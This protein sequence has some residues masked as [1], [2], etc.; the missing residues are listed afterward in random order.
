M[1]AGSW[2][3]H[4]PVGLAGVLLAVLSLTS[5]QYPGEA[6]TFGTASQYWVRWSGS[7]DKNTSRASTLYRD[8]QTIEALGHLQRRRDAVAMLTTRAEWEERRAKVRVALNQTVFRGLPPLAH[9]TAQHRNEQWPLN[10]TVTK[11]W[12]HPTL[13]FT[14]TMLHF[15]SQPG[16]IVTAGLWEPAA[17]APGIDPHTGQRAGVLYVHS[18]TTRRPFCPPLASLH[19]CP[20]KPP[21]HILQ[22]TPTRVAHVQHGTSTVIIWI[23]LDFRV[24]L[25]V[26]LQ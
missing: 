17:D 14:V 26:I 21:A 3:T 9:T 11:V 13:N 20:Q 15:E 7:T 6:S 4:S 10:A 25:H 19:Y 22:F 23:R 1:R 2:P 24:G 5:G 18:S 12:K 8:T 16:F